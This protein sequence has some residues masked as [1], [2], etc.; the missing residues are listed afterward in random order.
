MDKPGE[1]FMRQHY[2]IASGDPDPL[3]PSGDRFG[4]TDM[5]VEMHTPVPRPQE[6]LH[7][8][9]RGPPVHHSFGKHRSQANPDHGSFD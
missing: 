8:H 2:R 5:Q 7:E 9:H 4:V 3:W 6:H 1:K